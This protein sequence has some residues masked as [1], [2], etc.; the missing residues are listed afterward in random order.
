MESDNK[1]NVEHDGVVASDGEQ[2]PSTSSGEAESSSSSSSEFEEGTAS[3]LPNKRSRATTLS[4]W[5]AEMLRERGIRLLVY[6]DDYLLACQDRSKLMTQVAETLVFLEYLGGPSRT[7]SLSQSTALPEKIYSERTEE[8]IMPQNAKV[9][10][11]VVGCSGGQSNPTT[12]KA[13]TVAWPLKANCE[14]RQDVSVKVYLTTR[15]YDAVK[16]G[17]VL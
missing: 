9:P 10:A 5:V 6:L 17:K 2:F 1:E 3:P 12:Q 4:N 11:V 15:S 16:K 14:I 8:T 13:K 7:A